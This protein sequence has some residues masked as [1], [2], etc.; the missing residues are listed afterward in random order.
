MQSRRI[1]QSPGYK[2]DRQTTEGLGENRPIGRSLYPE[3]DSKQPKNI[4]FEKHCVPL[5]SSL[6]HLRR[7]QSKI[8]LSA[9]TRHILHMW[10]SHYLCKQDT[11]CQICSL[12]CSKNQEEP[13]KRESCDKNFD[14]GDKTKKAEQ[15][16]KKKNMRK[17]KMQ[18]SLF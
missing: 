8:L 9:I 18:K 4:F 17:G 10:T 3:R 14:K 2:T 6:R 12:T 13:K 7:P 5:L 16:R 15:I 11:L 1:R